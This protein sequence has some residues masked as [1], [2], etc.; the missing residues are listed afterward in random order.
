MLFL[1]IIVVF[2]ICISG[3][4]KR[5]VL[6][7]RTVNAISL[8]VAEEYFDGEDRNVIKSVINKFKETIS[9]LLASKVDRKTEIEKILETMPNIL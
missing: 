5:L 2:F 1:P 8:A 4:I 6:C 9:K 7:Q 3:Q